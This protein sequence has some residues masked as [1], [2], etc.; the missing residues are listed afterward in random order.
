[1]SHT[2]HRRS[3]RLKEYDYSRAGAYF[4]TIVT[5]HRLFLFG[6]IAN[7]VMRLNPMGEMV[8]ECWHALPNHYTNIVLDEFV[9]MPNHIHGI[10]IIN[11]DDITTAVVGAIHESPLP[12]SPPTESPRPE[13]SP[14]ESPPSESVSRNEWIQQ[15]RQMLLPK[16]IGR[17]KMQSAKHVNQHRNKTGVALWQRNYYE[18]IIRNEQS[19]HRIRNYIRNNPLQWDKDN[20]KRTGNS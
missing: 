9:I 1:M 16:I 13:S 15:R 18:H 6:E 2:H 7:G 4:V 12:E 8:A 17:F 5:H 11:D 3:I 14:T 20:E 19:L 10:I